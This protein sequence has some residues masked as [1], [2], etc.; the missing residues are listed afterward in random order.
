MNWYTS[1]ILPLFLKGFNNP[2][3]HKLIYLM[4]HFFLKYKLL[5]KEKNCSL[6]EWLFFLVCNGRQTFLISLYLLV[7]GLSK[8]L[9]S[10]RNIS[11]IF[12]WGSSLQEKEKKIPSCI[13]GSQESMEIS[14]SKTG[15]SSFLFFCW[16]THS[17]FRLMTLYEFCLLIFLFRR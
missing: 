16:C 9:P 10:S 4:L 13:N 11:P 14:V 2:S 12:L 7:C 15:Q 1:K 17:L 6:W 8:S 5:F 3:K